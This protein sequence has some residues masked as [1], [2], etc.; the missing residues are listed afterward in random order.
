MVEVKIWQCYWT[1][2]Q[3]VI[4]GLSSSITQTFPS[5]EILPQQPH[6]VL[7]IQAAATSGASDELATSIPQRSTLAAW[8]HPAW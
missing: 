6:R 5:G 7:S 1:L 8:R 2:N 4:F 3:K